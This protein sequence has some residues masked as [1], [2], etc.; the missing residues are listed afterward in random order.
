MS[1]K[2]CSINY[3]LQFCAHLIR[4]S[5]RILFNL[6]Y[7]SNCIYRNGFRNTRPRTEIKRIKNGFYKYEVTFV[8]TVSGNLKYFGE[9]REKA[10]AAPL[11]FLTAAVENLGREGCCQ[12]VGSFTLKVAPSQAA[13]GSS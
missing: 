5:I 3:L 2:L 7:L 10:K 9:N 6:K 1:E 8:K 13:C 12:S 11:A 4:L